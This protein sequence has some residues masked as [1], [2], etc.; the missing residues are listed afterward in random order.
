MNSLTKD[1]LRIIGG[2]LP[3]YS[4]LEYME[5][6]DEDVVTLDHFFCCYFEEYPEQLQVIVTWAYNKN[7]TKVLQYLVDIG[8]NI[9][10][11][12]IW[13][14]EGENTTLETKELIYKLSKNTPLK[15]S[16]YIKLIK[17]RVGS[18]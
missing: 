9:D 10:M 6:F 2:Y 8:F 7:K 17:Y 11:N 18:K 5:L 16:E 1:Q 12:C 13:F 3:I 15:Q 14:M 4:F